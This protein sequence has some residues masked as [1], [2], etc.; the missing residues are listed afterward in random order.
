MLLMCLWDPGSLWF[1][2]LRLFFH[3]PVCAK[4]SVVTVEEYFR[5]AVLCLW[6]CP[7]VQDSIF[8]L[9]FYVRTSPGKQ[10]CPFYG[11][12]CCNF[13][14]T[15][16]GVG[17]WYL[18]DEEQR[19]EKRETWKCLLN[20][21]IH[22][23]TEADFFRIFSSFCLESKGS[24]S[25]SLLSAG[26]TLEIRWVCVLLFRTLEAVLLH[27]CYSFQSFTQSWTAAVLAIA[28]RKKS[29]RETSTVNNSFFLKEI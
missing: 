13:H 2:D 9:Y 11:I 16:S 17:R 7:V 5:N 10:G 1:H 6:P 12:L 19:Q 26:G 4:C 25:F 23:E 3:A 14:S 29:R 20:L 15:K 27:S 22:S 21:G 28:S 24:T 18:T 8:Y